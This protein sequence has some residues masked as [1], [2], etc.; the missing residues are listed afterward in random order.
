MAADPNDVPQP[1]AEP[2]ASGVQGA[3]AAA[4]DVEVTIL[5]STDWKAQLSFSESLRSVH[6]GRRLAAGAL[7]SVAASGVKMLEDE[8]TSARSDRQASDARERD[9]L[10]RYYREKENAA[11]SNARLEAADETS[12]LRS[13][14]QNLGSVLLGAAITLYLAPCPTVGNTNQVGL[15]TPY[16]AGAFAGV[17][18]ILFAFSLRFRWPVFRRRT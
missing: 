11:V 6:D 10:D 2:E 5:P 7:F 18:L 12:R 15:G 17:A 9:T 4:R 16:L 13:V 14:M 3:Q 1:P 8:L